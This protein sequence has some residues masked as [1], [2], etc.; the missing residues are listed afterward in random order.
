MFFTHVNAYLKPKHNQCIDYHWFND[1]K[2][3]IQYMRSHDLPEAPP[4]GPS[5]PKALSPDWNPWASRWSRSC[6]VLNALHWCRWPAPSDP[7]DL[8]L[9]CLER[10][11]RRS[12]RLQFCI[13]RT[14]SNL[15]SWTPVRVPWPATPQLYHPRNG[16][17]GIWE[18]RGEESATIQLQGTVMGH[19]NP[20]NSRNKTPP[21][22]EPFAR[23]QAWLHNALS[24]WGAL[25]PGGGQR[26]VSDF[27]WLSNKGGRDFF[28]KW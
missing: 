1:V 15:D 8:C 3:L 24:Y 17:E 13:N 16:K 21:D 22:H 20:P 14:N 12:K 5:T 19:V 26:Q 2:W 23:S 18:W 9:P 28:R 11:E 4:T 25:A 7:L 10:L 27:S 6:H